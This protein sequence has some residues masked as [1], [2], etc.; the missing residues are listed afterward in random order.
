M[1]VKSAMKSGIKPATIQVST[2][3]N[4]TS[5]DGSRCKSDVLSKFVLP[6]TDKYKVGEAERTRIKL[7]GYS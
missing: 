2:K 3:R 5:P 4:P 6:P 1:I 7:L